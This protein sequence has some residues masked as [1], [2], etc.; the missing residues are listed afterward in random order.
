MKELKFYS[1]TFLLV[2]N[3]AIIILFILRGIVA[4]NPFVGEPNNEFNSGEI[5]TDTYQKI[6]QVLRQDDPNGLD[7]CQFS[8]GAFLNQFIGYREYEIDVYLKYENDYYTVIL[9]RS[10]DSSNRQIIEYR[11]DQNFKMIS[12]TP[13]KMMMH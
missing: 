5:S 8:I 7:P 11:I 3:V 6:T 9:D 12:K 13:M 2:L 4:L 10:R 1:R